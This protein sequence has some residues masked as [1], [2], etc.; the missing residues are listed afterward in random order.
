MP[1]HALDKAIEIPSHPSVSPAALVSVIIPAYNAAPYIRETLDSVF[2]QTYREFEVIVIND[3]SPD[4]EELEQAI[5]PYQK[6]IVYLKQENR[7]PSAARNAGI[8]HSHGEYLAFLD[9]DDAWYPEYLAGQMAFVQGQK[10]WLDFVY[11]NLLVCLNSET[12]G[13]PY[14]NACPSQGP[15]NFESLLTEECQ[16]PTTGVVVRKQKAI[17]AGLFDE[18][19]FRSEDYDLWL[20]I[21]HS[22][23]R[24]AY[25][26]RVLGRHRLHSESLS[27]DKL[28]MIQSWL[29]VLEKV[30]AALNLSPEQSQLLQRKLVEVRG[31]NELEN[32]KMHLLVGNV[33]L[34]AASLARA[35]SVFH[36]NKLYWTLLGLKFAPRLTSLTARAVRKLMR[37]G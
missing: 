26:R 30:D 32:G 34:A 18:S 6:L 12:N 31:F 1:D 29:K 3:G 13:S 19:F 10:P 20:R 33:D 35:N 7:G 36:T 8:L 25:Q 9:S 5:A 15:I 22:G 17:D 4:T 14:M 37:R 16:A 11:C 21:A 23:A 27:D 28:K 24:M 2:A